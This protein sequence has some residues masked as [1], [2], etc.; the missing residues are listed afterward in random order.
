LARLPT[1]HLLA[2]RARVDALDSDIR[3]IPAAARAAAETFGDRVA[4]AEPGGQTLSYRDLHERVRDVARALI[5]VRVRDVMQAE[6]RVHA[7]PHPHQV[8]ALV[9]RALGERE[10]GERLAL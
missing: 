1:E 5:V 9:H 3:T 2:W 10:A 4:V 8:F 6:R 7:R